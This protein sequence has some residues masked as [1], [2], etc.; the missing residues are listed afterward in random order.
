MKAKLKD[1]NEFLANAQKLGIKFNDV[2]VQIDRTYET[3]IPYD[4]PNWNIFRLRKQ[5]DKL[6]LTMKHTASERSRD[7]Y[8]YEMI[9][10]N[11]E[12]IIKILER[13][14]YEFGV[15]VHKKRR[16]AKYNGMELCLDE[17]DRLG[18]FVEAEKLVDGVVEIDK[19]RAVLWDL[20]IQL[21]VDPDDRVHKGYDILMHE[22]NSK[23]KL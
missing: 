18:N 13:L 16:I 20:L 11:E 19:I 7:N 8:E 23:N 1:V 6:I 10:E 14:G 12:E 3:Q 22:L 2:V 21:G 9:V 17:I 4:S 5:A 15:E